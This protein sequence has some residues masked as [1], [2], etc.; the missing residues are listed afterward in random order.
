[1]SKK[2][3]TITSEPTPKFFVVMAIAMMAAVGGFLFGYDTG[4]IAG[5]HAL[6]QEQYSLSE[7]W[8]EAITSAVL[9]GAAAGALSGG[10]IA[11]VIGRRRA[12]MVAGVIFGIGA[13]F[14][15]F[16]PGPIWLVVGRIV[17]GLGVGLASVVGPLYISE[18][19]P[20]SHRGA[21]VSFFQFAIVTGILGAYLVDLAFSPSPGNTDPSSLGNWRWMFG[22]GA[23]P[24][25]LL[26]IGFMYLPPSPRWL[27]MRGRFSEAETVLR[28][29]L[30]HDEAE[31]QLAQI[32]KDIELATDKKEKTRLSAV[33][34]IKLALTVAIGL[35]ILQQI[36]GINTV[37]YYGTD[38]FKAAG[39]E[40]SGAQ[41]GAQA[42]LGVVNLLAT[43]I[44][45]W[46]TDRV[47]RRPLILWGTG[48]MSLCLLTLAIGFAFMPESAEETKAHEANRVHAA[49]VHATD[50]ANPRAA[51]AA[52]RKAEATP[53][54][55]AD[56]GSSVSALGILVLCATGLFVA[57]FAFSLGPMVWTV[58]AEIFPNEVRDRCVAY[59]A[60]CNWVTNFLVALTFLSLLATLG[61]PLTFLMYAVFGIVGLIWAWIMVPETGG[62]TLEEIEENLA[63]GGRRKWL[64]PRGEK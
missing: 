57:A 37:L 42:G 59:A 62:Y 58:I 20:P 13:I 22:L 27:I 19:A 63:R 2:I 28:K 21:M 26:I 46:L 12:N 33:P 6:F 51:H 48:I 41:I 29:T 61:R 47:G 45:I 18:T 64:P 4:V 25:V 50:A 3:G 24:G 43:V 32:E 1:M 55:A 23:I 14:L 54:T 60:G 30:E 49:V 52:N 16:A 7:L 35:A 17:I 10:K 56:G 36:T 40:S 44:A 38:V 5:A 53:G 31:R 9:V 39:F 11:D 34:G 15:A 8:V